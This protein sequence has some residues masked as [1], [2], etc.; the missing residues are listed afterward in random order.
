MSALLVKLI[1]LALGAALS[2][3][4]LAAVVLI[5]GSPVRPRLR[6]AAFGAGALTV[7][8]LVG[9]GGLLVFTHTVSRAAHRSEAEAAVDLALGLVLLALAARAALRGPAPL[10]PAHSSSKRTGVAATLGLGV[11]MMATNLST[12]VLF[13][14]ALKEIDAAKVGPGNEAVALTVLIA[15]AMTPI[16][17]PI[18]IYQVAPQSFQ[19]ILGRVGTFTKS[20]KRAISLAVFTAFGLYLLLKG[21]LAI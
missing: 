20:H 10:R 19:H 15:I 7:L 17:L 2:P 18:T 4:I 9:I 21:A 12:L 6:I 16:W 3:V 8:V 13:L 1:P 11:A 14:G 5:L